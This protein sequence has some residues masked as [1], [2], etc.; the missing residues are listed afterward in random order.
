MGKGRERGGEVVTP[1][2]STYLCLSL[3]L[4]RQGNR[5]RERERE[6]ERMGRS[7]PSSFYFP[8]KWKQEK[9]TD[10]KGV[11]T[12]LS[13]S[14]PL[15]HFLS[16]SPFPCRKGNRERKD[17]EWKDMIWNELKWFDMS[18]KELTWFYITWYDMKW[19]D[20]IWWIYMIGFDLICYDM[21]WLDMLCHGLFHIKSWFK[22]I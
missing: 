6:K 22:M 8:K 4:W 1:S 12:S 16:R 11:V 17:G 7:P 10:R 14:L 15:L 2:F 20:M 9:G 21:A 18:W 5:E 13:L 19:Y 3:L